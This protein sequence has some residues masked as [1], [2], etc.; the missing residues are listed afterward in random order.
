MGSTERVSH[1]AR[2]KLQLG[3]VYNS[4]RI[5][6]LRLF[7]MRQRVLAGCIARYALKKTRN[8]SNPSAIVDVASSD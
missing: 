7:L 2:E 3:C 1:C 6:T 5:F 4:T 8:I